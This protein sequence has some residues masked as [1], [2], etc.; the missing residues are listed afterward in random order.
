MKETTDFNTN[1]VILVELNSDVHHSEPIR[2]N[3]LVFMLCKKGE[4][5]IEINYNEFVLK[6]NGTLTVHPLDIVTLKGCSED[7]LSMMLMLPSSTFAPIMREINFTNYDYIKRN[8]LVYHNAEYLEIIKSVFSILEK[9]KDI[10]D[11]GS[12]EKIVEKQISSMFYLQK[13]HYA[14]HSNPSDGYHEIISRKK[15]L[16][17]DFIKELISSHSVSR[18]VLFYANE[19]GISSGYL[20]EVCN[21]VSNHSAKE[22]IDSAVAARLK[23]ELS[24]TAKSIQEIA[25]EY[26][27]PSQSYFSRYYKRLTGVRPS[28]FR[29]GRDNVQERSPLLF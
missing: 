6:E 24:Y 3:H 26:N 20:N 15:E 7:F 22:I 21:E 23:Y 11:Y 8:P 14:S 28:D 19:L 4:V 12:F 25:D 5:T 17:R 16:F 27:F 13:C 18:E 9:V 10:V 1:H 2:C 29:K